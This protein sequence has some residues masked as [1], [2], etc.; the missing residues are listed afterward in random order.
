MQ[1]NAL[2]IDRRIDSLTRYHKD[3]KSLVCRMDGVESLLR[4]YQAADQLKERPCLCL[5]VTDQPETAE[6]A[7]IGGFDVATAGEIEAIIPET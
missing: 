6:L 5:V 3:I 4:M 1:Y 2:I 7:R